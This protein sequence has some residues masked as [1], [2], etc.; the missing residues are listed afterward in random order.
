MKLDQ[1]IA[2]LRKKNNLSQ[3]A[4]AKKVH[5]S[6]QAVSK[7]E[8]GQ[9]LPDI[10]KIVLLSEIFG[11]TTDYLLKSGDPSFKLEHNALVT[12]NELSPLKDD[13]IEQYLTVRKKIAK[14]TGFAVALVI[15]GAAIFT[16]FG[17]AITIF[18]NNDIFYAI[19]TIAFFACG[20]SAVGILIYNHFL[21]SDFEKIGRLDFTL[22]KNQIE[23]INQQ[24]LM[25]KKT[26]SK[27]L[28]SSAIITILTV[29]PEII[30]WVMNSSLS[31]LSYTYR[32]LFYYGAVAISL[33]LLASAVYLFIYY[34]LS[35]QAFAA[36]TQEKN[37]A[38]VKKNF[39]RFTFVYWILYICIGILV[40]IWFTYTLG[41]TVN[42]I[43]KGFLPALLIFF[44]IKFYYFRQKLQ[45]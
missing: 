26:E 44:L 36:L 39:M 25:Y 42:F 45:N 18:T 4:L 17:I 28:I 31:H 13:E 30:T 10:E 7:W 24:H 12:N 34:I 8:G 19:G 38:I 41:D 40:M 2:T 14:N 15:L 29:L 20:A 9:S 32:S 33:I 35:N 1:K 23:D 3:E 22:K 43:I 21:L 5:V 16:L 37:A 11:V 6:R 27:K